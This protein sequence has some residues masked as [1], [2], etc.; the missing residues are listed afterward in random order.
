MCNPPIFPFLPQITYQN[1]FSL[2]SLI[3]RSAD[4]VAGQWPHSSEAT[5][6]SASMFAA[7]R[8]SRGGSGAATMQRS[9]VAH[10]SGQGGSGERS[11]THAAFV[12]AGRHPQRTGNHA[13]SIVGSLPHLLLRSCRVQGKIVAKIIVFDLFLPRFS[14]TSRDLLLGFLNFAVAVWNLGW[15]F[16]GFI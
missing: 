2:P 3:T 16:M 4:E 14:V 1:S 8:S 12:G 15:I 11:S 13:A 9:L 5:R 7:H 6:G 10:R